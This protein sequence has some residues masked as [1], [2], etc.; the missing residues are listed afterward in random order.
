MANICCTSKLCSQQG[1]P[2]VQNDKV[3]CGAVG[4]DG[5]DDGDVGQAGYL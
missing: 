4:V 3:G 1:R 2:Q 5:G